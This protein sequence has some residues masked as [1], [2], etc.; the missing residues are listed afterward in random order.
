MNKYGYDLEDPDTIEEIMW[1]WETLVDETP[2]DQDRWYTYW[3][4]IVKCPL[5]CV[6]KVSW[7]AGSTEYQEV[8][9]DYRMAKVK[10]V[11]IVTTV[12]VEDKS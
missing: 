12:Y 8:D 2:E 1:G 6:Y 9:P 7:A 5:G 3:S 11:E 10:P 4:K